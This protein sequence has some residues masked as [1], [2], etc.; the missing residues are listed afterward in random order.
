[1]AHPPTPRCWRPWMTWPLH[2]DAA[3]IPSAA[4]PGMDSAGTLFAGVYEKLQERA[5]LDV[6][7]DNEFQ[8]GYGN[9]SALRLDPNSST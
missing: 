7:G 6:A 5:S 3:F 2:P 8:T 9:K 4:Q 1:M